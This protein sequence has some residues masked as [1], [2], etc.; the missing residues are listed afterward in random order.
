[1]QLPDESLASI[2]RQAANGR[3]SPTIYGRSMT[4]FGRYGELTI[5]AIMCIAQLCALVFGGFAE[6]ALNAGLE[7]F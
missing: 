3:I 2:L 5:T 6:S 7:R 4:D 1:M